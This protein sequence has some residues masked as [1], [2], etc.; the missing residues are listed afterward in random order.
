MEGH[1]D[2]WALEIEPYS[3]LI[4]ALAFASVFLL[5]IRPEHDPLPGGVHQ[6][7]ADPEQSHCPTH[8]NVWLWP[9]VHPVEVT[10]SEAKHLVRDKALYELLRRMEDDPVSDHRHRG[11]DPADQLLTRF[12][13][14][15]TP[16]IGRAAVQ[17]SWGYVIEGISGELC[18]EVQQIM[19]PYICRGTGMYGPSPGTTPGPERHHRAKNSGERRRRTK[20]H[21]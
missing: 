6:T 3:L 8:V 11:A 12:P 16:T 21:G 15:T 5:S 20:R 14:C 17:C 7:Q 18:P 2:S 10:I 9:D 19:F 4:L 13:L 1:G